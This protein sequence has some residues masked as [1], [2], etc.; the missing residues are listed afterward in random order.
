MVRQRGKGLER[1]AMRGKALRKRDMAGRRDDRQWN[2]EL[3]L[4]VALSMKGLRIACRVLAGWL[5]VMGPLGHTD[6]IHQLI[7]FGKMLKFIRKKNESKENGMESN[8]RAAENI[9]NTYD[10]S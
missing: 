7:S 9:K 5:W 3:K 1:R 2:G 4:S 8:R 6:N 10:F